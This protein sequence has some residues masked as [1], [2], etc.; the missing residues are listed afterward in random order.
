M[1]RPLQ[2]VRVLDLSRVLAGPYT[3]KLLQDLGADV[4]RVEAPWG[5]DTRGWGPPFT[6]V[7]GE[8][9]AAYWTSVN[10]GKQVIRRDLRQEEDLE[11]VRRLVANADVILENFRPGRADAWF[12]PWP[13]RAVV[14]SITAY[15]NDGPRR[16]EGGYDLAMQARSGLMSITGD[17]EGAPAK[18][19]V[20][21]IDVATGLHASAAVLAAL[22]R[23]E[24][25]GVGSRLTLSLWDC[26]LDLL[27]NQAQNALVGGVD[28]ERMGSAHPNLVPYRAFPALDGDIAVAVGSDAQWSTLVNALDIDV[29]HDARWDTNAGRIHDRERVEASVAAALVKH[30]RSVLE[31]LLVGIPSAPVNSIS[32]ALRDQQSMAR[33]AVVESDGV[34]HVASP[35]R[36]HT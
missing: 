16:D 26:A 32:D 5:D 9:V 34:P 2:G 21:V 35:H 10:L 30:P 12:A 20:A 19:G 11:D 4:L 6:E 14:C 24:R 8:K 3:A 23:R 13:E 36:F 25:E 29:P 7:D 27:I 17:A 33:N 1:F 28:P 18:V 15:G 31:D 22:F